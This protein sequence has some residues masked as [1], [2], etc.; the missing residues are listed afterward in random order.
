M[1]SFPEPPAARDRAR[2]LLWDACELEHQLMLQ[3]LFAAFTL[4]KFPDDTCTEAQLEAIRRWASTIMVVARQEMEHL[5]M[6]NGMLTAIGED[7][8]FA[9]DNLPIQTVYYL[10][11]NRA[12]A[13]ALESPGPHPVPPPTP[14]DIPFLWEK[15]TAQTIKRFVCAESPGYEDLRD[16]HMFP[17]WCFALRGD[18]PSA[19]L[20]GGGLRLA[21]SHVDALPAEPKGVLGELPV[22]PGTI[23]ELYGQINDLLQAHPEWFRGVPDR[24]V[25]V[26]VEYQISVL[27]IT[28]PLSAQAAIDQ[29]VEEGEGIGEPPGY[30]SH[31]AR[32]WRVHEEF[33]RMEREG[34]D[35]ALPVRDNPVSDDGWLPYTREV[36]ELLDYAY[37][38]LLYVLTSLYRSYAARTR[39]PYLT[40]ALQNIAFGPMMTMVV[41]PIAEVLVHLRIR[42]DG[43]ETAGPV[44]RLTPEEERTLWPRPHPDCATSG[45]EPVPGPPFGDPSLEERERLAAR[46][47]DIDFIL[48]RMDGLCERVGRLAGAV[49]DG[50]NAGLDG[51]RAALVPQAPPEWARQ[52]LEFVRESTEAMANNVRRLYQVGQLP[53]FTVEVTWPER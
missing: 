4:K 19:G 8:F 49:A 7:P 30:D 40:V 48:G 52:Q 10:G 29:I 45:A 33:E 37:V 24:Q 41:R 22:H 3:Y 53:Q 2:A 9:R 1:T 35:P 28:D 20:G 25:F 51:L 32:F 26:P 42:E 47:D 23:P 38:T 12:R 14:R 44:F 50:E 39:P 46:L 15:F 11:E 16:T 6:A 17:V 18:P 21:R 13:E 5:A 31:F 43:P 36:S 27:K 34:F